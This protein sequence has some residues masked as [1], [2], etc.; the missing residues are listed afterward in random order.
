[1]IWLGLSNDQQTP[2]R[3][4][5]LL[6]PNCLTS[7]LMYECQSVLQSCLRSFL[8]TSRPR[9]RDVT[10][11]RVYASRFQHECARQISLT[12]NY[13]WAE[14]GFLL[15]LLVQFRVG[16]LRYWH[17]YYNSS[18]VRVTNLRFFGS[19]TS[20]RSFLF[21]FISSRTAEGRHC[22]H[23]SLFRSKPASPALQGLTDAG[24]CY[25][26][27]DVAWSLHVCVSLRF[28]H[29][30]ELRKNGQT[31][32]GAVWMKTCMGPKNRVTSGLN[33]PVSQ[34]FSTIYSR[35]A[36]VHGELDWFCYANR[37]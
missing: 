3:R 1:M 34:I 30:S 11:W 27:R 25:R 8:K 32:R 29:T 28:C 23:P 4:W 21:S 6:A 36:S 22:H 33:S 7:G 10:N 37:F 12:L 2:S 5:L 24:Y 16:V 35:T 20:I 18:S 9:T 14:T 13:R 26:R 15:K 17:R 19:S 31:N